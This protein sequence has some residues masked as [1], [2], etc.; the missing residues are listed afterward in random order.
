MQQNKRSDMRSGK[1]VY[2][3]V[4]FEQAAFDRLKEYQ[5]RLEEA[6]GR[7]ITNG[8]VLSRLLLDGPN[9]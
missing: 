1:L 3:H 7:R 5:R 4:S 8:E 6:E 2:R 9:R